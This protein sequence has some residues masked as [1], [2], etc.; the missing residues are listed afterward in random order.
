MGHQRNNSLKMPGAFVFVPGLVGGGKVIIRE[1]FKFICFIGIKSVLAFQHFYSLAKSAIE[2]RDINTHGVFII[3][4]IKKLTC[5][6][7]DI[8]LVVPFSGKI[9]TD[10]LSHESGHIGKYRGEIFENPH[11]KVCC[12]YFIHGSKDTAIGKKGK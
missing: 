6:L 3:R 1:A 4:H 7:N 2:C 10:C 8:V 12:G 11:K 5:R 9:I